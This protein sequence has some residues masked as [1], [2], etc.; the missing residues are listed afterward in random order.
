MKNVECARRV[1]A[2][3]TKRVRRFVNL[4]DQYA[5]AAIFR[6]MPR[7]IL[8]RV[9]HTNFELIGPVSGRV[10]RRQMPVVL[11]LVIDQH[12]C[13][14]RRVNHITTR[15]LRER[16]PADEMRV[17]FEGIVIIVQEHGPRRARK[18]DR[19]AGARAFE[20]LVMAGFDGLD[21][22]WI[23]RAE[24]S[25]VDVWGNAHAAIITGFRKC[26]ESLENAL[27][28]LIWSFNP[29]IN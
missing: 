16:Q 2:I 14:A 17:G 4:A 20:R 10:C 9:N 23:E 22:V 19:V 21:M 7:N 13:F 18:Y 1:D 29:A 28:R 12:R 6:K 8:T 27:Q 5:L 3:D 25:L 11:L 26:R 15:C 24:T